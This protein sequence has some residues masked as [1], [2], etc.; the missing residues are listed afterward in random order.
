M[1]V[2]KKTVFGRPP[3]PVPGQE[4]EVGVHVQF[5]LSPG[6]KIQGIIDSYKNDTYSVRGVTRVN[7]EGEQPCNPNDFYGVPANAVEAVDGE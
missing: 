6:V 2:R 3:A 7:S 1:A 5:V 4:F